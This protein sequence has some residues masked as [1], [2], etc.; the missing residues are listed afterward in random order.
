[1]SKNHRNIELS[2]T[3]NFWMDGCR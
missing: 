2:I 1:M 3:L